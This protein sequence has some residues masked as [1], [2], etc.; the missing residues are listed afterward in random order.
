M[1]QV[2]LAMILIGLIAPSEAAQKANLVCVESAKANVCDKY[3]LRITIT[4]EKQE[5][6]SGLFG[7]YAMTKVED[8]DK[9]RSAYWTE[10]GLWYPYTEEDLLQPV[11]PTMKPLE[12]TKEFVVFR[13][14]KNDLC[15]QLS[16]GNDLNIYAWYSSLSRSELQNLKRFFAKF[17]ITGNHAINFRNMYLMANATRQNTGSLVYSFTCNKVR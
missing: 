7:I 17:E 14:R 11:M 5:G 13:G 6:R 8:P 4:T 3:E 2:I 1:K 15:N 9:A 12:K 10:N 16:N